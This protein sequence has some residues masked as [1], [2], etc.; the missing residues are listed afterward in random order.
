MSLSSIVQ[1]VAVGDFAGLADRFAQAAC[2][3]AMPA[4]GVLHVE[5]A[6]L[7]SPS[8][9]LLSVG[10][11]GDETA[12]IEMLAHLLDALADERHALSVELMIVVGNLDA[13]AAGQRFVEADM[14]RLFFDATDPARPSAEARRALAIMEAVTAFFS[15]E[16]EKGEKGDKWHFDLHAAIR[17]SHYH[18]FAVIPDVI[19]LAR[20]RILLHWL[21]GAGVQAAILNRHL[22]GTFSAWTARAFGAATATL[23]LGQVSALGNNN[24]SCFDVVRQ[25]LDAFMRTDVMPA[26]AEA[27]LRFRVVQEL[28]KH[29]AAFRMMLDRSVWNFTP[30]EPGSVIAE[31]GDRVYRVG[32]QTEYVVFPNPDVHIGLRAGLMLVR[33]SETDQLTTADSG[34][35]HYENR[36]KSL[37]R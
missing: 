29:S 32:A 28:V 34:A 7:A 14:N 10:I 18:A 21:G 24:L 27:P 11:H 15:D 19:T 12:P 23:E 20:R 13:I 1:S 4:R 2:R 31:E 25:A 16:G 37:H 6:G 5:P 30:M 3:V 8:R 36:L 26:A 33:D 35:G 22:A 17:P 9:L